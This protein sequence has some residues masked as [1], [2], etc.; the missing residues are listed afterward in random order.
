MIGT[1]GAKFVVNFSIEGTGERDLQRISGLFKGIQKSTTGEAGGGHKG[2]AAGL[3][4]AAHHARGVGESVGKAKDL[5]EGFAIKALVGLEAMEKMGEVG[6]HLV[7]FGYEILETWG[8]G[9][10]MLLH[11]GAHL[12]TMWLRLQTASHKTGE[13]AYQTMTEAVH[14]A[15][16]LPFTESEIVRLL[17]AGAVAHIDIMKEVGETYDEIAK[18]GGVIADLPRVMGE[19]MKTTRATMASMFADVFAK[20]GVEA[21]Y[22]N[23]AMHELAVWMETGRMSPSQLKRILGHDWVTEVESKSQG[24]HGS[25]L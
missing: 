13:Q 18:K 21:S 16:K 7:D 17:D 6:T 14:L 22:R 8:R 3:G 20:A 11:K 5:M 2:I 19:K 23:Q 1:S 10:E 12:E 9:F 24:G 15:Q 4:A 25:R